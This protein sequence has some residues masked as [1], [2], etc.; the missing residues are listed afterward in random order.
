MDAMNDDGQSEAEWYKVRDEM[1]NSLDWKTK[2]D[3]LAWLRAPGRAMD[4]SS[5]HAE[6]EWP[7][8]LAECIAKLSKKKVVK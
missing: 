2:P 7:N 4:F 1:Y 8:I 5:Y 6:E 3:M